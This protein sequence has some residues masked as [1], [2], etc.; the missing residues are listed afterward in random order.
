MIAEI[1]FDFT[2]YFADL[3]TLGLAIGGVLAAVIAGAL[4]VFGFRRCM[5]FVFKLWDR[6]TYGG[7]E[8]LQEDYGSFD[9]YHRHRQWLRE[10]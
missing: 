10:N 1:L 2:P 6:L 8:H 7:S 4:L 5:L 9:A 3:L